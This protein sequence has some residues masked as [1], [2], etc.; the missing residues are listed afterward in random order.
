MYQADVHTQIQV[1]NPRP[2]PKYL[3]SP[4]LFSR[5]DFK[6]INCGF[7]VTLYYYCLLLFFHALNVLHRSL[8]EKPSP[9][10][11]KNNLQFSTLFDESSPPDPNTV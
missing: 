1:A 4:Y 11:Q 5:P 2:G 6:M 10:P 7:F 9:P 8:V 3:D